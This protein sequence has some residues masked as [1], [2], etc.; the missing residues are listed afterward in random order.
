MNA[1]IS[2]S[3]HLLQP[4]IDLF[5]IIIAMHYLINACSFLIIEFR[6]QFNRFHPLV[7]SCGKV[8][9]S[10]RHLKM[11]PRQIMTS[12][13]HQKMTPRQVMRSPRH[14]MMT[15]RQIIIAPRQIMI[16]SR[17]IIIVFRRPNSFYCAM[18]TITLS[19]RMA[20]LFL[21]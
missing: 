7:T 2:S 11:T 8:M 14:L 15:P 18:R 9:R 1:I 19:T 5:L 3:V 4:I 21:K 16:V 6:A 20:Q 17:Q 12:S 13:R 10:P